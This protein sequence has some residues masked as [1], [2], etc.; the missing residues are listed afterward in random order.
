MLNEYEKNDLKNMKNLLLSILRKNLE[1]T[2][3]QFSSLI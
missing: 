1:K 3:I 2:E